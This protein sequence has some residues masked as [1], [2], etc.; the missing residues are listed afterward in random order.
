MVIHWL[1][2][3]VELGLM[4]I[5]RYIKEEGS[6]LHLLSVQYFSYSNHEYYY[7]NRCNCWRML[8]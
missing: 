3:Y 4:L 7:P 8:R 1:V 6:S 2:L 5:W